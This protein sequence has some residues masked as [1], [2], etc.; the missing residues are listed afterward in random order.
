MAFQLAQHA[1]CTSKLHAILGN[2]MIYG[3][4]P[5]QTLNYYDTFDPNIIK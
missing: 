2:G 5:G 1:G 3:Y 4:T